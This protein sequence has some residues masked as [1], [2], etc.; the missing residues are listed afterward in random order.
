ML[1]NK[2]VVVVL[3]AYNAAVTL[4][5]TIASDAAE[6]LN[7]P[8]WPLVVSGRDACDT[9]IFVD[10]IGAAPKKG[11]QCAPPSLHQI[12]VWSLEF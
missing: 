1:N 7:P 8:D 4:K 6:T 5:N 3:P 10:G 11:G 2:K 9:T 12:T